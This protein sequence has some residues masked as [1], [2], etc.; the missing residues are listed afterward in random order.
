MIK[1]ILMYVLVLLIIAC[2]SRSNTLDLERIN[3]DHFKIDTLISITSKGIIIGNIINDS[4]FGKFSINRVVI[5]NSGKYSAAYKINLA[6]K[7]DLFITS[8]Y[9]CIVD[10]EKSNFQGWYAIEKGNIIE[11]LPND[12]I[13][14]DSLID[15]FPNYMILKKN[16]IY[17]FYDPKNKLEKSLNYGNL[18]GLNL[19][20][21]NLP[22]GIYSLDNGNLKKITKD[23]SDFKDIKDG[24]Y[25]V[26][27]PGTNVI[28]Y[29]EQ[30]SFFNQFQEK[31][32]KSNPPMKIEISMNLL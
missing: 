13:I 28:Q 22:I 15:E 14:L 21:E 25:F 16:G 17:N 19:N 29:V 2:D 12:K 20:F 10:K 18:I 7:E 27:K 23:L 1:I 9:L 5:Q 8:K 26:S 32:N 6:K 31:M 3:K 24:V 30:E 4:P 11:R